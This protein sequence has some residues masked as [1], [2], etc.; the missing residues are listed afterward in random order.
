MIDLFAA[1]AAACA[2]LPSVLLWTKKLKL[3]TT[4]DDCEQAK[5]EVESNV[6]N[7][8]ILITASAVFST[9]AMILAFGS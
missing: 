6:R 8:K 1:C 5:K 9:V 7:I 2:Y 3:T 4:E